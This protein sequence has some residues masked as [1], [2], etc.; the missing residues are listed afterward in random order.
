MLR[1]ENS[2]GTVFSNQDRPR[3]SNDSLEGL[4]HVPLSTLPMIEGKRKL[5]GNKQLKQTLERISKPLQRDLVVKSLHVDHL[6]P[7]VELAYWSTFVEVRRDAA[8]A[9]ATLSMNS[10][11][12]DVLS[13]AGVLGAILSFL[14]EKDRHDPVCVRD[15]L[16]A[17]SY[18]VARDDIKV[19]LALAPEGL[20]SVFSMIRSRNIGIKRAALAVIE[21]LA[22]SPDLTHVVLIENG[23]LKTLFSQIG[24]PQDIIRKEACRIIRT[25]SRAHI[26]PLKMFDDI[27]VRTAICSLDRQG[28]ATRQDRLGSTNQRGEYGGVAAKPNESGFVTTERL[29]V[30]EFLCSLPSAPENRL[31]LVRTDTPQFLNLCLQS[32]LLNLQ[33]KLLAVKA[34]EMLLSDKQ[35]HQTLIDLGILST[36]LQ[37]CF[38]E[39][40]PRLQIGDGQS[41]S[42]SHTISSFEDVQSASYVELHVHNH[43]EREIFRSCM[44]IFSLLT[45]E[46][47]NTDAVLQCGL[48]AY[49]D[50]CPILT[51]EITDLKIPRTV[52]SL[53]RRLALAAVHSE[54]MRQSLIAQGTLD[55]IKV[56][57]FSDD[58]AQKQDSIYAIAALCCFPVVQGHMFNEAIL[59]E[60]LPLG[61]VQEDRDTVGIIIEQ[62]LKAKKHHKLLLRLDVTDFLAVMISPDAHAGDSESFR[63]AVVAASHLCSTEEGRLAL[64]NNPDCV[65]ALQSLAKTY[66][67]ARHVLNRLLPK[68]EPKDGKETEDTGVST[69]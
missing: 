17:L 1:R 48:L 63:T 27:V 66:S 69:F 58:T 61:Y 35:V 26:N 8:A 33:H 18:M 67:K 15:A 55:L 22:Q 62:A 28:T 6:R 36:I 39:A 11:N 34:I 9:F 20:E 68:T 65:T 60:I 3:T 49:L 50:T 47:E 5:K 16:I 29:T 57:L 14:R 64:L 2:E 4:N 24:H 53:I 56:A 44:G 12:L 45:E 52:T 25:I 43:P 19:R 37:L 51:G 10:Q 40:Y 21:N 41:L 38:L 42:N 46:P 59:G 31:P 23:V 30:L 7:L 54:P 13:K 32:S